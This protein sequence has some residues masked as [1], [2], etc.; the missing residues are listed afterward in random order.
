MKLSEFVST[1]SEFDNIYDM[2]DKE[3]FFYLSEDE[4][5]DKVI[6]VP[7]NS[8]GYDGEH[9]FLAKKCPYCDK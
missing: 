1:I 8:I 6:A 4:G 5:N 3:M 2:F 7:I 9:I